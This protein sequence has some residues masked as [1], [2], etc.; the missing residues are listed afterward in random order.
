MRRQ[1]L[2]PLFAHYLLARYQKTGLIPDLTTAK[3]LLCALVKQQAIYRHNTGKLTNLENLTLPSKTLQLLYYK[4]LRGKPSSAENPNAEIPRFSKI[5]CFHK[6]SHVVHF[7]CAPI[8]FLKI[9]LGTSNWTKL[10]HYE[11]QEQKRDSRLKSA[12]QSEKD[13]EKVLTK[14]VYA[15]LPPKLFVFTKKTKSETSQ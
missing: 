3:N 1:E 6:K 9:L 15:S 13:L 11:I 4:L 10:R 8:L 2:L 5:F 14:S 7:D 12:V